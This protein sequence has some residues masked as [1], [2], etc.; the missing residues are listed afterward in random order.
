MR[1]YRNQRILDCTCSSGTGSPSVL[2]DAVQV[3]ISRG[4][5]L[6]EVILEGG[7]CLAKNVLFETFYEI[8]VGE[9]ISVVVGHFMDAFGKGNL[10]FNL[11]DLR[12]EN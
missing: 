6:A 11:L 5:E 12:R 3:D 1:L 7:A 4:R 10:C 8:G 2:L 9:H